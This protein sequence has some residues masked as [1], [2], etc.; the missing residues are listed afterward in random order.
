MARG[1]SRRSPGEGRPPAPWGS[2]PLTEI[3]VFVGLVLLIAGF[4]VT[5]PRG[6]IMIGAGLVLASLAGLEL[7]LRE[8]L[9]GFRSHTLILAGIGAVITLAIGWT[10]L[11][12]I[13]TPPIR[14]LLAGVVF[15]AGAW[16]FSR[17]FARRSGGARFK[18]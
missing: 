18:L 6:P 14:I 16:Y 7:A 1:S 17:L 2:F 3:V 10:L 5:P 9:A 4:F 15:G 13:L 12:S 11:D 8:H